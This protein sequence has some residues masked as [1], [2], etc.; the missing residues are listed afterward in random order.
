MDYDSS[1]L[2]KL[3]SFIK[4]VYRGL[5]FNYAIVVLKFF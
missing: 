1:I 5:K 4:Q 3:W 2:Y